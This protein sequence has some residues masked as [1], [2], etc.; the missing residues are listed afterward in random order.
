MLIAAMLR[1]EHT[2]APNTER[3]N[4][5]EDQSYNHTRINIKYSRF[6]GCIQWKTALCKTH[7]QDSVSHVKFHQKKKYKLKQNGT[8]SKMI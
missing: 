6:K 3:G 8:L 4:C 2:I 7:E 1:G 5:Q